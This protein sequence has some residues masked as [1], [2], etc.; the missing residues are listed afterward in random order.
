[1]AVFEYRNRCGRSILIGETGGRISWSCCGKADECLQ[2][3]TK[4]KGSLSRPVLGSFNSDPVLPS[5]KYL[6]DRFLLE[7]TVK[8]LTCSEWMIFCQSARVQISMN[9][10]GRCYDNIFIERLWRSLE[11]ELIYLKVFE[12]GEHLSQKVTTWFHWY[13][14]KRPHQL[15]NYQ[16]SDE[17]YYECRTKREMVCNSCWNQINYVDLSELNCP[18]KLFS[19]WDPPQRSTVTISRGMVEPRLR[20]PVKSIRN[21]SKVRFD[22]N[23][24]NLYSWE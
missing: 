10:R 7:F 17:I 23:S 19:L 8:T 4:Q 11:Y 6:E 5:L 13:N 18:F 9:R 12:N 14:R 16:T 3:V 22:K 24:V 1:M 2:V 15:L 20:S 21:D